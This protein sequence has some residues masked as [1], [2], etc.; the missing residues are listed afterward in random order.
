MPQKMSI[1]GWLTW[2]SLSLFSLL[3]FFLQV[4]GNMLVHPM[5]RTFHLNEAGLGAFNSSFFYGYVVVQILAGLLFDRYHL[6]RVCLIAI[7]TLALGSLGFALSENLSLALVARFIMGAGSGFAF[8]GMVF[9]ASEYFP[10]RQFA[11][12]VGIGEFIAMAGTAAAQK[13]APYLIMSQG[14]Q[15]L[16][17]ICAATATVLFLMM[18]LCIHE[19]TPQPKTSTLW[20]ELRNNVTEI[21][22]IKSVW[23]SGLFCMASFGVITGFAALW[24][25]PF[26]QNTHGFNYLQATS[27]MSLV[28]LGI[29]IGG[30]IIGWFGGKPARLQRGLRLTAIGLLLSTILVLVLPKMHMLLYPALFIMGVF[31]SSYVLSFSAVKLNT[32]LALRGTGIGLCN[33]I[34]LLG[35]LIFQP[36]GGAV[37]TA[38]KHSHLSASH[39]D[40]LALLIL[41]IVM[42]LALIGNYFIHC[43]TPEF[44][45]ARESVETTTTQAA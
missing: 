33:T 38:L 40:A 18:L 2:L 34:A 13:F 21:I 30:P 32:P 26:L 31:G 17:L 19:P 14:W 16:M 29:A 22:K 23:L 41:P 39:I 42:L 28:L 10:T 4:S 45:Q 35:A 44:T 27:A 37:M 15:L 1:Q 36:V 5:M 11:M 25:V 7:T 20:Q 6:R 8:V 9:S 3:Q 12:M 24:G 43:K